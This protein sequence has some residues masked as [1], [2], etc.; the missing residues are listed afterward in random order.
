MTT[1]VQSEL[2][3]T[4][5]AGIAAENYE[6]F[7]VPA[8]GAP[9][10]ADLVTTAQLRPGERILD[11]AC[12]TGVVTRLAAERV[13]PGGSV[14]GAD[15]TASMLSV[16]RAVP[17]S[18]PIAIQWYETSAEAMPFPDCSFD[19]VL[20]QFG[21]QF[22]ADRPAAVREMRRVL[23]PGGRLVIT[24]DNE[25]NTVTKALNLPRTLAVRALGLRGRRAA[26]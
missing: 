23:A 7:F 16:A 20:C 6:R 13:A 25:R 17:S 4:T 5:F 18:A 21:L 12:G 22:M 19:V 11:V 24:T 1:T 9:F 10:A 15:I 26:R 3:R 8:I 14:A 2:Y